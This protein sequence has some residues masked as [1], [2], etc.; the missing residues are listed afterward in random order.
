[1]MSDVDGGYIL[2][3]RQLQDLPMEREETIVLMFTMHVNDSKSSLTQQK[4][5]YPLHSSFHHTYLKVFSV[6]PTSCVNFC[7][8]GKMVSWMTTIFPLF[9]R[10]KKSILL[11]V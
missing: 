9:Y 3:N 4:S 5:F 1:M 6:V 2:Y 10:L 8:S 11:T 7:L